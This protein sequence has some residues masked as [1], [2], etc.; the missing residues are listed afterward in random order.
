MNDSEM[1][2]EAAILARVREQLQRSLREAVLRPL[3][4]RTDAIAEPRS[5][6]EVEE[7]MSA[8]GSSAD[9]RDVGG[10]NYR[11]F[12]GGFVAM[13]RRLAGKAL[14]PT[15]ERQ[16]A[17]NTANRRVVEALRAEIETL[18][19]E[20]HATRQECH[21]LSAKLGASGTQES[22]DG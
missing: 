20:L 13:A 7:D 22:N 15:L 4:A 12:L 1:L 17:Y 16:V 9:I 14:A 6:N 5:A 2:D 18:K 3:A 8:L 10:S 21:R 11:S 19:A